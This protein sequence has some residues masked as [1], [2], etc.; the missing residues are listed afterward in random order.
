[1]PISTC[2]FTSVISHLTATMFGLHYPKDNTEE[3][4]AKAA[5]SLCF[6]TLASLLMFNEMIPIS[7]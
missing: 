7:N 5:Q 1:M 6:V 3:R 2:A 4:K